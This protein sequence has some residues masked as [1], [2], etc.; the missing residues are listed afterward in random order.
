MSRYVDSCSTFEVFTV[1]II[2]CRTLVLFVSALFVSRSV[3]WADSS[4]TAPANAAAA[5]A[6]S[7][8]QVDIDNFV[9]KPSE[10]TV[11]VGTKITWVNKDDVP[12]TATS[13]DKPPVFDSKTLD[14]DQK[15][16]FTF[17]HT[18]TYKYFC[19]VHPHMVGTIT[20]K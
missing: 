15:F 2:Q 12:H 11:G 7:E 4:T 20:V 19:K 18:G 6:P 17:T 10:I 13:T 3:A 5:S 16:S 14:T 8:V 1:R 9:F